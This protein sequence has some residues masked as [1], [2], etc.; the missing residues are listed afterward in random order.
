MDDLSIYSF[1][2]LGYSV[3]IGIGYHFILGS[4]QNSDEDAF[5]NE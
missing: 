2:T 5:H 4:D 3:E 1:T